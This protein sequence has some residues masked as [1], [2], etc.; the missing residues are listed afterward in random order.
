MS[1]P[2]SIVR[3]GYSIPLTNIYSGYN[4]SGSTPGYSGMGTF[5][6]TSVNYNKQ[7][8][9]EYYYN[10]TSVFPSNICSYYTPPT[11]NTL[12]SS[13]I[14]GGCSKISFILIGGGG[15]NQGNDNINEVSGV[16]GG[17]SG[18]VYVNCNVSSGMSYSIKT[19]SAGIGGSPTPFQSDGFPGNDSSLL[20]NGYYFAALGGGAGIGSQ[21]TG[22]G[23]S[24]Y[25]ITA[26]ITINE[27]YYGTGANGLGIDN[28]SGYRASNGLQYN[29]SSY[30]TGQFDSSFD[31]YGNG[32]VSGGVGATDGKAIMYFHY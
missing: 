25:T 30:P 16:N 9:I 20:I 28:G 26:G 27:A 15:G 11:T 32:G 1:Y 13:T 3:N 7:N 12:Y 14:P 31:G 10:G 23:G 2:Y 18:F 4:S 17:G 8:L 22:Y 5:S 19:G 24:Y 29:F 6:T 21:N